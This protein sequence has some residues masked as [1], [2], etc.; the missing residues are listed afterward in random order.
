MKKQIMAAAL[1]VIGSSAFFMPAAQSHDHH[2]G[3]WNREAMPYGYYNN[4]YYNN[5]YYDNRRGVIRELRHERRQAIRDQQ[6][7]M[8]RWDNRFHRWF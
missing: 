4:G 8:H 5:G 3:Y 2:R 1:A 6:R 7:A